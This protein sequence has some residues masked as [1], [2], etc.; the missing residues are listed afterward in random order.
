MLMCVL[1]SS[2]IKIYGG[3]LLLTKL[4]P[5]VIGS[6]TILQNQWGHRIM[7]QSLYNHTVLVY[8]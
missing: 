4:S 6:N 8:K 3:F 1:V 2:L 7:T 5:G